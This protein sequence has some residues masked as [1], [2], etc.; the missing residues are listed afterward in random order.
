M[1][2]ARFTDSQLMSILNKPRPVHQW[3]NCVVSTA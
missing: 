3:P 2:K 1:K